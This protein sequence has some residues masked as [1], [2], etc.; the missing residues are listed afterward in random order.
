MA[1][2]TSLASAGRAAAA[3]ASLLPLLHNQQHIEKQQEVN[4]KV[5]LGSLWN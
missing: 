2:C 1:S 3:T 5:A 4:E